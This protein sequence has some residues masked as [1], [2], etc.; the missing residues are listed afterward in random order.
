M[1]L[2][3]ACWAKKSEK[4]VRTLIAAKADINACGEQTTSP[5]LLLA[6]K[7]NAGLGAVKAL[8]EARAD[9]FCTERSQRRNALHCIAWYGASDWPEG[10]Q[11]RIKMATYVLSMGAY[12]CLMEA[13][14]VNCVCHIFFFLFDS[15][16]VDVFEYNK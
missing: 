13:G 8:V 9:T 7:N 16:I 4:T 15:V 3:L 1:P 6:V 12:P 2:Q 10:P 5:P 14:T 11:E